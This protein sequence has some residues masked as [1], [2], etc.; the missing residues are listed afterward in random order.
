[1]ATQ[2]NNNTIVTKLGRRIAALQKYGPTMGQVLIDGQAYTPAQLQALYQKSLDDRPQVETARG[3]LHN[4]VVQQKVDD[5]AYRAVDKGLEA[6]VFGKYGVKSQAAVDFGYPPPR[7]PKT[8]VK[9]KALAAEKSVA[10][11]AARHTAGKKQKE[12]IKVE[13]PAQAVAEPAS[14]PPSPVPSPAPGK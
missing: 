4:L 8:K 12:E 11:R 7:K 10:T 14:P 2:P 5:A 13:P 1:M 6:F 3:T 9:V